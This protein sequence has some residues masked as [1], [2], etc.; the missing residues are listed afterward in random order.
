MALVCLPTYRGCALVLADAAGKTTILYKMKLGE[1]VSTIPTIGFNVETVAYKN[2]K[3]MLLRA[4]IWHCIHLQLQCGTLGAKTACGPF[5]D[6]IMMV[7]RASSLLWI[8]T[9]ENASPWPGAV[10][11]LVGS[12]ID[13]PPPTNMVGIV[14]LGHCALGRGIREWGVDTHPRHLFAT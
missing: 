5:G 10:V 2:I 4:A 7:V 13:T 3:C 9:I 1:I 12:G 14:F 8:P 6:I 11:R